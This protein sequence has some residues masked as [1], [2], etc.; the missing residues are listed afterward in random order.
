M[1]ACCSR[2]SLIAASVVFGTLIGAA[3]CSPHAFAAPITTSFA[4]SGAVD[5]PAQFDLADLQSLPAQTEAVSFLTGH[6]PV[7][8]RFTGPSLWSVISSAGLTAVPGAK[9][10]DLRN[11]VVAMGSDGYAVAY[12]GG[13][14]DPRFGGSAAVPALVAYLQNGPRSARMVSQG[15]R[16]RAM[17]PEAVT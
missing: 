16:P 15:P 7:S 8:A 10:S 13:E 1:N 14:L 4:L 11:V 17:R 3:I 6:G 5:R 2:T 12:S 9:N